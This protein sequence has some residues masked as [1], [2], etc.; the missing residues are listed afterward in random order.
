MAIQEFYI[1]HYKA[2]NACGIEWISEKYNIDELEPY[3]EYIQCDDGEDF[4][5]LSY[6]SKDFENVELTDFEAVD[7]GETYKLC[8]T[9]VIRMDLEKHPSFKQA[10]NKSDNQVVARINFLNDGKPIRDEDGNQEQLFEMDEDEFVE[11]E[12]Q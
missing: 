7:Q 1:S 11:L 3:V 8:F 4:H 6:E 10:L 9:A 12:A 2:K 5:S